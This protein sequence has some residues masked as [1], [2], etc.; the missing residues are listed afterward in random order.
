VLPLGAQLSEATMT[1]TSQTNRLLGYPDDARLL[2]IN[3]DDFG[4][5][6]SINTAILRTLTDGLVC[7]TTLMVP[8]PW[9]SHAMDLL[10]E[11]PEIAFGVHLTVMCDIANCRYAP[12]TRRETVPSLID[13]AGYFY[14]FDRMSAFLAQ[15]RLDE[16][17]A[18]WRAQIEAVLAAQLTPTHLDWH[19]LRLGNRTDI[20]DLMVALAKEYGLACRVVGRQA[21]AQVQR[22]GL[23]TNDY[24]FLDSFGL[25]LNGKAARYAQLLRDLPVGLSEWAV[26]PG[27]DTAELRAI[28]PEGVAIRQSDFDFLMSQAARDLVEAEGI[29][30]LDYRPL[31]A[32]WSGT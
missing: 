20:V 27:F 25:E 28:Q 4:V 18:E 13:E 17:E 11:Q 12:L 3:A 6:Q 5:C 14:S 21:I 22:Q 9:S 24:D 16:L 7:S 32:V 19:C 1:N 15:V 29:I 31:Q 30:L 26:H 2:L 8:C 10:K 23:P